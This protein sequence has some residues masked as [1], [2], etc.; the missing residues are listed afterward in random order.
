MTV[1]PGV[2]VPVMAGVRV[3]VVEP[4]MGL[5]KVTDPAAQV[6]AGRQYGVVPE[7]SALVR[8]ATQVSVVESQR[9]VGARQ[10]VVTPGEHCTQTPAGPQTGVAPVQSVA[11]AASQA[12]HWRRVRSQIGVVPR[13]SALVAHTQ[14]LLVHMLVEH[15]DAR[16]HCTQRPMLVPV[17]AQTGVEP[18][19]SVFEVQARQVREVASQM[20]VGPPQSALVTHW[21]AQ[22]R[23][24]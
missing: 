9:G 4:A 15:C 14:A 2:A 3:D 12:R 22:P 6:R 7:Q 11:T 20:G 18:E 10:A 19:Q 8:H 24:R 5:R 13:Q 16:V 23:K 17:V 21:R 1:W